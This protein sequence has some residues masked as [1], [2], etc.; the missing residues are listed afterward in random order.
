MIMTMREEI[1]KDGQAVGMFQVDVGGEGVPNIMTI[2]EEI[3]NGY[4]EE[5]EPIYLKIE[6]DELEEARKA[7]TAKIMKMHELMK[8][9]TL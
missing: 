3:L 7:F 4:T 9:Q 2:R 5:G 8:Q 6:E 1:L